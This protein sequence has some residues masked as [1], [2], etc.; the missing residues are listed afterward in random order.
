MRR[1]FRPSIVVP[2]LFAVGLVLD[3]A[4]PNVLADQRQVP[5]AFRGRVV[6]VPV[7]VRVLD[8][9]GNPVTDLT[10]SDFTV[11][12]G[13]ERQEIGHF[14]TQAFTASTP[15]NT[16]PRLR[17]GP[18]LE[19]APVTHRTF[20]IL[21]GRGR[22]QEPADGMDAVI[23]MVR[24]HLLP[25]DQVGVVAYNRAFGLTTE[26]EPVIRLLDS[27]RQRHEELEYR[28]QGWFS[29][30]QARYG[31][32]A[33][34]AGIQAQIDGLFEAADVPSAR[35]LATGSY[36]E[37]DYEENQR[38][39]VEVL[40]GDEGVGTRR[41]YDDLRSLFAG[42]EFLRY[43][44]GEKHILF[45]SERGL[46]LPGRRLDGQGFLFG[47]EAG[48]QVD[49]LAELAADARVTLSPI[50]TGGLRTSGAGATYSVSLTRADQMQDTRQL[51]EQTGGVS[52][53]Y[54]AADEAVD[55]LDRATRFQYLLGYYPADTEWNGEYRRI[56]VEVNRPGATVHYRRGYRAEDELVPYDRREFMSGNRIMAAASDVRPIRDIR[57]TLSEPV[58]TPTLDGHQVTVNVEIDPSR[59]EFRTE[60]SRRVAALH[61]A[62]FAG[63]RQ[64]ELAGENW[65][66]IDLQLET[67]T[68]ARLEREN[69]SHTVT[70]D[71][72][73]TVRHLKA[74]VYD[75]LGD[76]LGVAER[77]IR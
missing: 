14:S 45:L 4:V 35:S 39:I 42:I 56:R 51:A 61:V 41:G 21:L 33:I 46:T 64:E 52:S 31:S 12:E 15:T 20:L 60:G 50:Q 13:G 58:V 62:V 43:L 37:E 17:R 5:G 36:G 29:G 48:K 7:D 73:G 66:Q 53:F 1:S 23:E 27:Y 54:R 76:R 38:S 77:S 30:L 44:E 9:A 40:E 49:G 28:L 18:G 71:A 75:Y 6:L 16:P 74:V 68:F 10:E 72:T 34:P 32:K 2:L 63:D 57:V 47:V 55:R 26:R 24:S 70:L 67:E 22:L 65:E 8:G 19:S 3:T 11:Y 59:I 69:I 25:Q